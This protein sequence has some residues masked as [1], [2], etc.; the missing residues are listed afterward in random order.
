MG[1]APAAAQPS[2][3]TSATKLK[4]F[5]CQ[6]AVMPAQRAMSISSV[7]H[8]IAGTARMTMKFQ[9]LRRTRRH[10]PSASVTGT[11]LKTWLSPK[12]PTLG[13]RPGDTWVVKHPVVELSA[14]SF[15]RFKVTFRW[16]DASGNVIGQTDR[17]SAICFQPQRQPD[18]AVTRA[19]SNPDQ[20]GHYTAVVRN[21]G[22]T[23]SSS[24]DLQVTSGETGLAS[25]LN[26]LAPLRP[27][28][29][30]AVLLQ[31]AACTSGE[32]L[33]ITVIPADPAADYDAA[34]NTVTAKCL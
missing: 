11:G 4:G 29:E 30:E 12:D 22:A 27:H 14:P 2:A 10:G 32:T 15:Y 9:L 8:P 1:V 17:R 25:S 21:R 31:G 13:S 24:F 23:S 18:L 26:P 19:W 6:T 16:L 33:N 7:M 34:D 20:P 5:V 3:V 28:T